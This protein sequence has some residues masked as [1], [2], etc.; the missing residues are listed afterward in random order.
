MKLGNPLLWSSAK[1]SHAVG[2]PGSLRNGFGAKPQSLGR[3]SSRES[4]WTFTKN[5]TKVFQVLC[6][7]WCSPRGTADTVARSRAHGTEAHVA[8]LGLLMWRPGTSVH[9]AGS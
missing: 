3:H 6:V 7:R 2:M 4:V 8:A 1:D 5:L 9:R